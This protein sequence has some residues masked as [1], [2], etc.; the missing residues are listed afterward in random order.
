[1]TSAFGVEMQDIASRAREEIWLPRTNGKYR[2]SRAG[3]WVMDMERPSQLHA[4]PTI[5]LGCQ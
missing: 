2:G 3:P 5:I 4:V 1:M